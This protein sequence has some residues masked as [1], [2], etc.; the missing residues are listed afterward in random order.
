MKD[1]CFPNDNVDLGSSVVGLSVGANNFVIKIGLI[2]L[3]Q[4]TVQFTRFSHENPN[5]RLIDF[6]ETYDLV[7]F[8]RVSNVA[9]SL[10]LFKYSL[11]KQ[12]SA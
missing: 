9:I 11:L 8:N 10:R 4:S 7:K 5:Q 1:Y 3:I 12:S 2:T 6:L